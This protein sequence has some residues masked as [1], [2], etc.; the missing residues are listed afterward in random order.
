M[1][2]WYCAALWLYV[3]LAHAMIHKSLFEARLGDY[4]LKI[5]SLEPKR[6]LW[7]LQDTLLCKTRRLRTCDFLFT[8]ILG[9]IGIVLVGM[10]WLVRNWPESLVLGGKPAKPAT[11]ATPTVANDDVNLE[12]YRQKAGLSAE[13]SAKADIFSNK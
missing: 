5:N 3:G 6:G 2:W 8:A 1:E 9:P 7:E 13:A 12:F 4:V 10:D 11:V